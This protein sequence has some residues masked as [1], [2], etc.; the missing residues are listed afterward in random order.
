[1]RTAFL[2]VTSGWHSSHV[3]AWRAVPSYRVVRMD[4]AID[5]PDHLNICFHPAI[6]TRPTNES[7]A[8]PACRQPACGL[9]RDVRDCDC[10]RHNRA[11]DE[12]GRAGVGPD[13]VHPKGGQASKYL[14]AWWWYLRR[15]RVG[16]VKDPMSH[17]GAVPVT[18]FE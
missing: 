13:G 6:E 5:A 8:P 14:G 15:R 10:N 17:D 3:L 7:S 4:L 1:M 11:R 16:R 2:K 12:S 18:L 9:V